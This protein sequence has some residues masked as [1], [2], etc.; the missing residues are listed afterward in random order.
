MNNFPKTQQEAERQLL[1][2]KMYT[3]LDAIS[4]I[5]KLFDDEDGCP[6]ELAEEVI[7]DLKKAV[8]CLDAEISQQKSKR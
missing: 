3:A 5:G 8:N 2:M 6:P 1:D 4:D 7:E